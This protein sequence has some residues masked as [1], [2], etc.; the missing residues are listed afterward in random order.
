ML[1][2]YESY[3]DTPALWI[4][5]IPAGWKSKKVRELFVER[6]M[7]VSD[8]DY[9]PLSVSKAGIV[10]QLSTAVK[11]DNGDNRKLVKAGD[12][13][14]NSRSDRKG[15][16]GVSPYDGSV[17]LI[18]IALKPITD[19][20]PHFLHYLLRSTP[21][22]EEYYRNGRG[23][24]SDLWTTRYSELKNIFLPIPPRDEQDHIVLFL[25]WK[26][27]EMAHFIHEKKKEIKFLQELKKAIINQ[28]VTRGLHNNVPM[29][30]T[31]IE[32]LPQIPAHWDICYLRQFLFAVSEKNHPEMPLLSVTREQG[33]I[34]RDV[35]DYESNHNYIPDDLS[36][37][38][39]VCKGQFVINKMKAWQGSYG[40][41][42]F[43]GIVSPAY[44]IFNLNFANKE[45]FHFAIRS[46]VYVNF[47]AQFSDGI[48]TGQWDLSMQKMKHIPFFV[49]PAEE[50]EEI[51]NVVPA[52][53]AKIE[54]LISSLQDEIAHVQ[55]LRTKTIA[56][57]V[58]G[59]ADVRNID[60]P[61]YEPEYEPEDDDDIEAVDD[62][63]EDLNEEESI[64]EGG[65]E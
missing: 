64:D 49:P 29:K 61:E 28:A 54:S 10:P 6:R 50:Q 48:R 1:H 46:R 16:S 44:F 60:I 33:V 53:I 51:L 21:F 17:S 12:F 40:V 27:S 11:T 37:Y 8:K 41:S 14:I 57:V 30:D 9:L 36:G 59:K 25:D 34:M 31:G 45:Y 26:T 43:D 19:E 4:D 24:V 18:N 32:W 2:P 39:L 56:D 47:F 7:K 22:T 20:N 35:D 65:D 52:K 38:K 63:V 15:S 3:K 42:D 13:V 58:T 23:L 5:N 55:E 62:N